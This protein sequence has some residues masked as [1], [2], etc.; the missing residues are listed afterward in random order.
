MKHN[1]KKPA[2]AG[3]DATELSARVVDR[4]D[5]QILYDKMLDTKN[6]QTK[7]NID[8]PRDLPV[9]PEMDLALEVFAKNANNAPA[10]VHEHLALTAPEYVTHLLTD[11]PMYRPGETV[12]YRSLTLDR[13]TLKPAQEELRCAFA[14]PTPT[15]AKF[16][17]PRSKGPRA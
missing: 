7:F 12:H 15:R 13:F 5:K 3:M 9:K 4:A 10:P 16:P 17:A 2:P 14:L 11:R 1:E 6:G 8:L